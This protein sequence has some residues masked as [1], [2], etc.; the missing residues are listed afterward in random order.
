MIN[1]YK[2]TLEKYKSYLYAL[3]LTYEEDIEI[4]RKKG[5]SLMT[6]WLDSLPNDYPIIIAKKDN[7][8]LGWGIIGSPGFINKTNGIAGIYIDQQ[9]R[10]NGF[11]KQIGIKLFQLAKDQGFKRIEVSFFMFIR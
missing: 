3:T 1:V 2:T 8:I 7:E 4:V 9:Y 5:P 10:G 6:K 11:A